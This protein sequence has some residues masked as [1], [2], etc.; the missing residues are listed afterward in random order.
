MKGYVGALLEL[1]LFGLTSYT[2]RQHVANF[3]SINPVYYYWMC[4]SCLTGFWEFI[5]VCNYTNVTNMAKALVRTGD[6]VWTNNYDLTM[7]LPNRFARLFY[8][9]YG[10]HADREY[11]AKDYWSRLIESSHA[12]CCAAM[13]LL[14]LWY[15]RQNDVRTYQIVLAGGMWSQ[16]MNSLLYLGAY[17]RQCVDTTNPNY[18]TSA[19][20]LGRWLSQRV[21]MWI[22]I[23]WLLFPAYIFR[24]LIVE[25]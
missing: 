16:F 13:C 8:S 20:P 7:L 1:G 2:L 5:F 12:L 19:F 14:S 25:G 3:A 23:F 21:F 9:E 17:G 11:M 6:H 18:V 15:L 10:A 4:F 22:N 24:G